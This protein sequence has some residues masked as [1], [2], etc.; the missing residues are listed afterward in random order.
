MSDC[1]EVYDEAYAVNDDGEVDDEPYAEL[2]DPN[3]G[4]EGCPAYRRL[5]D[6][7][8]REAEEHE[9]T[10]KGCLR[11][12]Q[13]HLPVEIVLG[14]DRLLHEVIQR[15][16]DGLCGHRVCR[17]SVGARGNP[18]GPRRQVKSSRRAG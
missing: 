6:G 5:L 13:G 15:H 2:D 11:C 3:Y 14:R 8:L 16:E 1:I 7:W 18:R 4:Y 10:C 12:L 9:R 17:K